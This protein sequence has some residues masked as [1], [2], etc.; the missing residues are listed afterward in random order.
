MISYKAIRADVSQEMSYVYEKVKQYD[1]L[2]RKY[3]IM[4]TDKGNMVSLKGNEAIRIRM[5]ADGESTPYVDKWLDD[6]WEN[7]YP[8]LI[9][10]SGML[11]KVGKVKYEFVIQEPGS[12]AVISTRQQNLLIQKSLIDYDGIIASEDFDVL[13]HL[14]GQATT[15]PELINDINVSLDDVSDKISEVNSTMAEYERQMQT[16]ATE[17]GEMK[18]D[19]QDVI[20]ALHVYMENVENSAASS[21]RLSESWAIGGTNSRDGEATNNSK[22]HSDQS[23]FYSDAA[24]ASADRAEEYAGHVDP[25]T[26][27]QIIA[28]DSN[29]VLGVIGAD[30][31]SQNLIN[32]ISG[33]VCNLN[34]STS[35]INSQLSQ[36]EYNIE[37]NYSKKDEVTNVMTPKGSI[38]Y[39]SLPSTNNSVGDYYYCFDGDGIHGAGNYVW[40][41]TVWYFGGAGD[42]GYNELSNIKITKKTDALYGD[43]DIISSIGATAL[44]TE[45]YS[46]VARDKQLIYGGYVD[47][48][49][50][51]LYSSIDVGTVKLCKF[52]LSD[53]TIINYIPDTASYIFDIHTDEIITTSK[54]YVDKGQYVGLEFTPLSNYERIRSLYP[55]SSYN[56]GF[57]GKRKSDNAFVKLP[58]YIP[59]MEFSFVDG[60]IWD[61]K[62]DNW[63]YRKSWVAYGDSITAG[64][65]LDFHNDNESANDSV[66]TYVKRVANKYNMTFRNMGTSGRGYSVGGAYKLYNTISTVIENANIVTVAMGTNDYGT[67]TAD[68][69]VTFGSVS[70]TVNTVDDVGNYTFCAYVKKAFDKLTECYPNSIIVIMTPIPRPTLDTLN[71]EGKTLVEYAEAIKTIA[72][73]Y[74]FYIIDC[75]SIARSNVKSPAWRSTYMIDGVHMSQAYHDKYY[76]PMIERELLRAGLNHNRF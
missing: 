39:A 11:S 22:F 25:K 14:I 43:Y 8:I 70:D 7:G 53:S 20:D 49:K 29:G 15:I 1:N 41:G 76:A 74:G 48:I 46:F 35:V 60:D 72:K 2:S 40:N 26:L 58:T 36:L 33:D 6:P 9:M 24:Q 57:I 62:R 18:T 51:K 47:K 28:I 66:N 55:T 52:N 32:K 69:S 27:S 45:L 75:L 17:Y 63:L 54:F 71:I 67:L 31:N 30:V 42:N 13:S 3:R 5:W 16:Y 12:P 37:T 50:I 44:G 65:K 23:K 10:T 4:I 59:A 61:I 64:Y 56:Y 68:N 73:Y 19:M 21:A 38:A 34:V